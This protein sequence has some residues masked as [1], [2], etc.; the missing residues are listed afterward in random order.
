MWAA[1]GR[2]VEREARGQDSFRATVERDTGLGIFLTRSYKEI[3][4]CCKDYRVDVLAA[5]QALL[6][7]LVE[8]AIELGLEVVP[9]LVPSLQASQEG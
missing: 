4:P 8:P 3:F 7:A 5:R 1:V 2:H 6:V 9:V